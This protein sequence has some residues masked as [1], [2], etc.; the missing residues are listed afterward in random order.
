MPFSDLPAKT[1]MIPAFDEE[2]HLN[3]HQMSYYHYNYGESGKS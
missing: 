1:A 2:S 3:I